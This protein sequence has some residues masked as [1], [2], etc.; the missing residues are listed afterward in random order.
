MRQRIARERR[1]RW[2]RVRGSSDEGGTD[3]DE[4]LSD[5]SD[6]TLILTRSLRKKL[7]EPE[8]L[9]ALLKVMK[10]KSK[11]RVLDYFPDLSLFISLSHTK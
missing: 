7:Y 8:K 1:S 4:G 6:D 3:G 2:G 9:K 5:S 10:N 11:F